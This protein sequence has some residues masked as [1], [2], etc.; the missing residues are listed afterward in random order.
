MTALQG[1]GRASGLILHPPPVLHMR[2]VAVATAASCMVHLWLVAENHHG[3]WLNLLMLAMVAVCLP[4][5]VHIWRYLRVGALRK[6]TASAVVMAVL[7]AILLLASDPSI[8]SHGGAAVPAGR[9]A[10]AA[11]VGVIALELATALL[12]ATLVARLRTRQRRAGTSI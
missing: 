4:C 9:A 5:S 3:V 7:H 8:H 10:G 12:A 1:W 11:S 2:L 6:V